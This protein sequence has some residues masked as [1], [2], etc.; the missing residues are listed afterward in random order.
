MRSWFGGG[1]SFQSV[2]ALVTARSSPQAI[3]AVVVGVGG[4]STVTASAPGDLWFAGDTGRAR[5]LLLRAHPILSEGARFRTERL[6]R[7]VG[8]GSVEFQRWWKAGPFR[9]GGA[10]FADAA[11]TARRQAGRGVTDVDIGAGFRGAYPGKTAGLRIDVAKGLRDG[12]TAFS[13][14]YSP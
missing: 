5:P 14:V 7:L 11:R 4:V 6:G 10:T 1:A 13:V 3:G 12:A 9:V 2:E 8:N